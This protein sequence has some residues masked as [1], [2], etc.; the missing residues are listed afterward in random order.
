M[1]KHTDPQLTACVLFKS[2]FDSD[3]V[4]ETLTHFTPLNTEVSSVDKVVYLKIELVNLPFCTKT[5]HKTLKVNII[6]LHLSRPKRTSGREYWRPRISI[7]IIR[8][9]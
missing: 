7:S 2:I 4:L 6:K 8:C 3:E 9:L 1:S 5:L